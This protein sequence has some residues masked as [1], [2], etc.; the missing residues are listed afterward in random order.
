M[1]FAKESESR[2]LRPVLAA[3]V[4]AAH[5]ELTAAKLAFRAVPGT[6]AT[7]GSGESRGD[8]LGEEL[9]KPIDQ[10]IKGM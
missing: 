10:E 1:F 4:V 9:G 3:W 6:A 8:A 2:T 7:C 5:V